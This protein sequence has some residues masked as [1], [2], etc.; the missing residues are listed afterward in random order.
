M[1][2][3]RSSNVLCPELDLLSDTV[4]TP[5]SFLIYFQRGDSS[6]GGRDSSWESVHAGKWIASTVADRTS[7]LPNV[8]G[9]H[10]FAACRPR[11][12][13]IR[14]PRL[15]VRQV[16][17]DESRS[18]GDWSNEISQRQVGRKSVAQPRRTLTSRRPVYR[19]SLSQCLGQATVLSVVR[20]AVRQ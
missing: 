9:M 7:S 5:T 8:S 12:E 2:N 1:D 4:Q 15:R 10:V 17:H 20:P 6:L 19:L 11:H 13:R 18:C 3:L 16:L 14:E